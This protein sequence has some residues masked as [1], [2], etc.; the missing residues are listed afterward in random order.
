M[1]GT[2]DGIRVVDLTTVIMGPWAAQQLGDMGADVIKIE[3]IAGDMTRYNGPR[4]SEGMASFY[5]SANRNKRSIALDITT[6]EG[7]EA[8]FRIVETADVVMHNMRPQVSKKF[9][10]SY[11][12]FA[13]RKPDIIYCAAFGFRSD[14]PMA[15]RPAYDDIIQAACGIAQLQTITSDQPRFVPTIIA[16]KASS[17]QVLTGIL[18]ALVSK[19]RTG[20]GQAIEVPMFESMVDLVMVEHM[21][22]GAFE[23]PIDQ[24]GYPRL[25]N[26]MRKPY[27]TQDGYLA[28][29]PYTDQNWNDL[30]RV[31]GR[32]DMIG[33][34]H[35][36]DHATRIKHSQENYGL[37]ADIIATKT[38]KYWQ[39][40]LDKVNVPVQ[41]VNTME[42]LL[43]DE[44]LAA[45]G[46]WQVLDHPTEGKMRF[47]S[48][49]IQFSKTPSSIRKLQPHLGQHSAEILAEAGYNDDEIKSMMEAKVSRQTG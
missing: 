33:H 27:A 16:D 49:P 45:T 37:L 28:V 32:E 15:E 7:R 36:V 43:E 35:F 6:E 38:T 2:L 25:L 3:T 44:Q 39:T 4:R 17:M 11:E 41:A 47:A 19:E 1:T 26:T 48:P 46:F 30:F 31:A 23:P 20:E 13:A 5:L 29:L 8:L 34:P 9:G 18:A 12:A 22:G 10:F 21:N 14:G 24:L 40:E 42:D